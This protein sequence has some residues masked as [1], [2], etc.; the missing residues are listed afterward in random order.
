MT[1]VS[2]GLMVSIGAVLLKRELMDHCSLQVLSSVIAAW[3]DVTRFIYGV[4]PSVAAALASG[5]QKGNSPAG[6]LWMFVNCLVSAGYVLGMRKRIKAFNF[7]V[8]KLCSRCYVLCV[9]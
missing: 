2:F 9:S 1:L 8:R 7:K 5:A 3:E 6:Y 4:D